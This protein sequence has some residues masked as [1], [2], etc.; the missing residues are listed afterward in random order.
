MA[1]KVHSLLPAVAWPSSGHWD[2]W[3]FVPLPMKFK[4]KTKICTLLLLLSLVQVFQNM[5]AEF[6]FNIANIF[7]CGL[8]I[9]RSLE[10]LHLDGNYLTSLPPG[11][12]K[13]NLTKIY[14]E[15]TFT[16]PYFWAENSL[17]TPQR[18]TQITAWFIIVN[19]I[20][21]LYEKIPVKAKLLLKW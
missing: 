16:H 1:T 9:Y 20:H 11:I 15:N 18:L 7:K 21:K 17:N 14:L 6:S 5:G 8:C 4:K 3:R 13:L 10:K 2:I 19:N 12:L